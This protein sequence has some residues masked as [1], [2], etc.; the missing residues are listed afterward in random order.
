VWTNDRAF[1]CR[2]FLGFRSSLFFDKTLKQ[3]EAEGALGVGWRKDPWTRTTLFQVLELSA[4]NSMRSSSPGY[5]EQV[6]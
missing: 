3:G 6:F 2:P 4:G 1:A 5:D